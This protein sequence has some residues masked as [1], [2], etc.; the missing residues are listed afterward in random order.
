M[1]AAGPVVKAGSC[2]D[3]ALLTVNG[4]CKPKNKVVGCAGEVSS[5]E[6]CSLC[7]DG[8]FLKERESLRATR[9]AGRALR[10]CASTARVTTAS[11]SQRCVATT[12]TRQAECDQHRKASCVPRCQRDQTGCEL[13][14]ARR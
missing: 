1:C 3:D 14:G 11:S 8:F 6:S 13:V 9:R 7:R 5:S 2:G 10:R 12:T 4:Q